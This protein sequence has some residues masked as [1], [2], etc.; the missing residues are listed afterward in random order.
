MHTAIATDT[1]R[2]ERR[3]RTISELD[4]IDSL[5]RTH[6]ARLLRFV[7]FSLGDEDLAATIVQDCFLRAYTKREQFRGDSSV[8]TWLTTIALNLMRDHQ[9]ARKFQFWRKAAKTSVEV[10]DMASVLAGQ[11]ASPETRLMAQQKA[12]LVSEVVASLSENQRTVFLLRFS[13]DMDLSAIAD[14]TGMKLNTVKTHLHRA[15]RAVRERVGG[16]Q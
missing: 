5:V 15:V 10:M 9:R 7:T 11:D 6:R 3:E 14:V 16:A 8:A 1:I 13:E 12:A 4:D 2:V